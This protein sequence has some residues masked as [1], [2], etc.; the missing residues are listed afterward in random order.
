M[1]ISKWSDEDKKKALECISGK[2]LTSKQKVTILKGLFP[3]HTVSSF[4][5]LLNLHRR[6]IHRHLI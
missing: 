4:A 2:N 1:R 6:T 3:Y 5:L